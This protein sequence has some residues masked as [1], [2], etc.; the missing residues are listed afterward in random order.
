MTKN[1]T[2]TLEIPTWVSTSPGF[3]AALTLARQRASE[4]GWPST[5]D[6]EWLLRQVLAAG[7]DH[8]LGRPIAGRSLAEPDHV[9]PDLAKRQAG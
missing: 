4:E 2:E 8:L 3:S 6:P 5:P 1:K 9:D 7:L